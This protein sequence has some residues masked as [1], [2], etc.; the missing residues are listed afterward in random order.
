MMRNILRRI[1]ALTLCAIMLLSIVPLG[2]AEEAPA[3]PEAEV[4]ETVLPETSATPDVD[5]EVNNA[6]V[7]SNNAVVNGQIIL[8][9]A[10]EYTVTF[11]VGDG[12]GESKPTSLQPIKVTPT[13]QLELPIATWTKAE[14][15]PTT[16]VTVS[17]P[18]KAFAGW[19]TDYEY[20]NAFTATTVNSDTIL[21][22]KWENK[23]DA[24]KLT[25]NYKNYEDG[26]EITVLSTY[27]VSAD[28]IVKAYQYAPSFDNQKL[29]G[30]SMEEQATGSEFEPFVFGNT[31][32]NALADEQK[33]LELFA[34]YAKSYTVNFVSDGGIAIP[35]QVIAENQNVVRPEVTRTGYTIEKWYTLDEN[36]TEKTY[37][38]NTPVT[39]DLTIYISWKAERVS[40]TIVYM[41]QNADDDNYAPF[42]KVD[43]ETVYAPA[44]S[45]IYVDWTQPSLIGANHNLAYSSDPENTD[46][47]GSVTTDKTG[48]QT[49]T[50]Q[51]IKNN[52]FQYDHCTER[53][54]VKPDGTTVMLVY[55]NRAMI[56]MSFVYQRATSTDQ[57]VGN[58]S[59]LMPDGDN[60]A[61]LNET[62]LYGADYEIADPAANK[63]DF[64]YTFSAK[65]E[66]NILG[67]WPRAA[68]VT[69]DSSTSKFTGWMRPDTTAQVSNMYTVED[70]IFK[71]G[72]SLNLS[73][74]SKGKLVST[75]TLYAVASQDPGTIWL[76]YAL[77]SLPGE[78][79]H[80]KIGDKNY[81]VYQYQ[82]TK[83]N[84]FYGQKPVIGGLTVGAFEF[85]SGTT[86]V[87]QI[88]QN[89]MTLTTANQKQTFTDVITAVYE[90]YNPTIGFTNTDIHQI[91][92][93]NRVRHEIVLYPNGGTGGEQ[94]SGKIY[95]YGEKIYD[96]DVDFLKNATI[97]TRDG[98]EF[99]GWYL[100]ENCSTGN[101]FIPTTSTIITEN[102]NLYAKWKS[103]LY[104]AEFY[105]SK[106]DPILLETQNFGENVYLDQLKSLTPEEQAN[107]QGWYWEGPQGWQEYK[108]DHEVGKSYTD[109]NGVLK[110]YAQWKDASGHVI[111]DSGVQKWQEVKTQETHKFGSS[112]I[113]LQDYSA[114][115]SETDTGGLTFVG[116]LAPNGKTYQVGDQ[117]VV[118]Y[119][120]MRFVAQWSKD[121]V[122]VI[123]H[124]NHD[125]DD[126]GKK[127]WEQT[128]ARNTEAQIWGNLNADKQ[129]VFTRNDYELVGWSLDKN[130][131][132]IDYEIGVGEIQLKTN[133]VDLYA[134]WAPKIVITKEVTG[135][136]GVRDLDFEFTITYTDKHDNVRNDTF[137]LKHNEAKT[138]IIKNATYVKITETKVNG[139]TVYINKAKRDDGVWSE[140]VNK[141]MTIAYKNDNPA[142]PDTGVLLD[143]L[144][145]VL[146]LGAAIAGIAI[147]LLRKRR[148][149]D[150]E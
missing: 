83:S 96:D 88:T 73:L 1:A 116:W 93:Y 78:T 34:W 81:T 40:V 13:T 120:G 113:T 3:V 95:L 94:K 35:N 69:N 75:P 65:Y 111:F 138:F 59:H 117:I 145:Y 41:L 31:I 26:Q 106:E 140:K 5:D 143:S 77:E 56:T 12:D 74:D 131:Q 30:W 47:E 20:R 14:E 58:T 90:G 86:S 18:F 147:F 64:V 21:Y 132:N 27:L 71:S 38:F 91:F 142:N 108:F 101:E 8:A 62:H 97:P 22:A 137:T 128:W 100:D 105:L 57:K 130:T 52:Y 121:S 79:I 89:R 149:N 144:P 123:Y 102:M 11:V 112:M 103:T 80:F 92:I 134:V 126:G 51:D 76:M 16:G 66:Q 118:T 33:E 2:V 148:R 107:I 125:D 32:M 28:H 87:R 109:E 82:H 119:D 68:W 84:T 4:V 124:A 139:Y 23:E 85:K 29:I 44:G 146:I 17:V 6:V 63:V 36:G 45:Y 50:I 43:S 55:Y 39:S 136:F 49:K 127:K 42:P 72:N 135:G 61:K 24:Y 60:I 115:W 104:T 46:N 67:M 10:V 122:K 54:F 9:A 37:D 15:D 53:C 129:S 25:Y 98:Y 133:N 48:W 19:Y 110:L 99:D 150:E 7:Y 70:S 114:H 141:P